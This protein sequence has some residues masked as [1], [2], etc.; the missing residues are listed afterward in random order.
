MF[1]VELPEQ[2]RLCLNFVKLRTTGHLWILL[3]LSW[4]KWLLVCN[5]VLGGY[6][7]CY[8]CFPVIFFIWLSPL[9][10]CIC[11][12]IPS[13]DIHILCFSYAIL[14]H[15]LYFSYAF[16]I[17][18]LFIYFSCTMYFSYTVILYFSSCSSNCLYFHRIVVLCFSYQVIYSIHVIFF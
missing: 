15:I 8:N 9:C 6:L 2:R 11:C 14:F 5:D 13:Y 12:H 1:W 7:G 16:H 3:V 10:T 4:C 17:L 18:Y